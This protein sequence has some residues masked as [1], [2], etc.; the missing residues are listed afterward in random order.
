MCVAAEDSTSG[1]CTVQVLQGGRKL[2]VKPVNLVIHEEGNS[3]AESEDDYE[4]ADEMSNGEDDYGNNADEQDDGDDDYVGNS[5]GCDDNGEV[6]ALNEIE[7]VG[8]AEMDEQHELCAGALAQLQR[9]R[10]VAALEQVLKIY[11]L[12]FGQEEQLLD[13]HLYANVKDQAQT[14]GTR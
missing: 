4:S 6:P 8:V 13:Q 12:H 14:A 11:E 5:G 10:T 2:T 7:S 9:T 1:R 3:D